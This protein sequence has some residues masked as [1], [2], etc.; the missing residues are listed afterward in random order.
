VLRG[1]LRDGDLATHDGRGQFRILL[2]DTDTHEGF[3]IAA[4]LSIALRG[5]LTGSPFPAAASVHQSDAFD[6]KPG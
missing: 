4:R 3:D 6:L 5:A 2:P 1:N